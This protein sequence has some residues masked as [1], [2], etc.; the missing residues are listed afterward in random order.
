[1]CHCTTV[2]AGTWVHNR[3]DHVG[4]CNF[5]LFFVVM[6]HCQTQSLCAWKCQC[7][8]VSKLF[9]MRCHMAQWGAILQ[10]Y[11]CSFITPILL[12]VRSTYFYHLQTSYKTI[13]FI[14]QLGISLTR[15]YLQGCLHCQPARVWC[16]PYQRRSEGSSC[17][18]LPLSFLNWHNF[19]KHNSIL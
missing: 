16:L 12:Y 1:M 18:Y 2:T 11:S 7:N 15:I 17:H 5:L 14:V 13:N 4:S 6:A 3:E 10:I 8:V 19:C 9:I